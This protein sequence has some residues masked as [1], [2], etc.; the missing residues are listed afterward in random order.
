MGVSPGIGGQLRRLSGSQK[1]GKQISGEPS[2]PRDISRL[3]TDPNLVAIIAQCTGLEKGQRTVVE[4][5]RR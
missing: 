1:E 3:A 4:S 5:D 2:A